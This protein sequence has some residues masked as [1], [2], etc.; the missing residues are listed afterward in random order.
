MVLDF[1]FLRDLINKIFIVIE[2]FDI[3]YVYIFYLK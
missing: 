1:N 2:Y 3:I